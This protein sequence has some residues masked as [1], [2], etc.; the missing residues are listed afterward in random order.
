MGKFQWQSA[1]IFYILTCGFLSYLCWLLI[2][3]DGTFKII[4]SDIILTSP[5]LKYI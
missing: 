1:G 3:T 5:A 4:S 2:G